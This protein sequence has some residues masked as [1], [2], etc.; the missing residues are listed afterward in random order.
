MAVDIKLKQD[1]KNRI[2]KAAAST[3]AQ[4]GY[5]G[6]SVADIA[7]QADIGKGTIYEYFD[8]KEDLFFAVF[9]WYSEKTGA[10]ATVSISA[11]G[12]SAAQR[13]EALNKTLMSLWDEIKDVFA[14]VMEFWAASSS[15]WMRQR[16][17]AA[18]KQLYHDFRSIVS[19]LIHD[20]IKRG[21]FREDVNP[22]AVAAALVGTWDAMFL[23]AWF[24][25]TFDPLKISQNFLTVV[26]QGLTK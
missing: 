14:L 16:F 26:I 2:I 12:G 1:K 15:T 22:E 18:F 5:A 17:Q 25:P 4:K 24:D 7:S 11:L 21:E 10:A 3:F 9:E 20:G 6:A 13:L 19:D 23:Q 8:S